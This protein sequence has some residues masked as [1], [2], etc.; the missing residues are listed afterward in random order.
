[1][2]KKRLVLRREWKGGTD[3]HVG[4]V[5]DLNFLS[6]IKNGSKKLKRDSEKIW[7]H[8]QVTGLQSNI[9]F[10]LFFSLYLKTGGQTSL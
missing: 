7:E 2:V 8:L 6:A 5:N 9:L 10:I 4:K 3:G 1:M